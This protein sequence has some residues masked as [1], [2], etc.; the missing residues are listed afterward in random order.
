MRG[1]AISTFSAGT[2]ALAALAFF[3][4]SPDALEDVHATI[5][6]GYPNVSHISPAEYAVLDDTDLL[7]FDT[8]EKDEF[9]VSH[10]RG[11]IQVAPDMSAEDFFRHYGD[12]AQGKIVVFYCSV[13]VRSSKFAEKTQ[14]QLKASGAIRVV[15]LERGLFG[16]HNDKRPLISNGTGSTEAIH[17]Y[18]E[19]WGRLIERKQL[20]SYAP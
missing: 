9:A 8:R 4:N 3:G 19:F 20:T 18:D 10:L 13:G 6:G 5:V 15:N 11:A 2:L 14:S 1:I 12:K 7:V 17:P 16:W